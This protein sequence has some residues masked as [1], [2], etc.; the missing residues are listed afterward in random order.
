MAPAMHAIMSLS[1][2]TLIASRLSFQSQLIRET[3]ALRS[4]LFLCRCRGSR[5]RL[6]SM[7]EKPRLFRWR[8]SERRLCWSDVKGRFL[9]FAFSTRDVVALWECLRFCDTSRRFGGRA[10]FPVPSV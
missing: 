2:L 3:H 9:K 8:K 5:R 1:P 4:E 6:D 7:Q 10:R